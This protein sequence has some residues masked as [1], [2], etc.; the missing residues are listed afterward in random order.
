[1]REC[2]PLLFCA[3][4]REGK[5]KYTLLHNLDECLFVGIEVGQQLVIDDP[6]GELTVTAFDANH[7]SGAVMFL[8]EGNFGTIL[9][10]GDCRLTPECLQNLPEKY[11]GK[12]GKVPRCQ[13]DYLFLD[14]TFGKFSRKLPSKH[15]AIHQVIS[16]IWK[17]PDVPVVYLTC[18]LLGQEEILAVVSKTFGSKIF[19][20]K[21]S[22]PEC[23]Q[24]LT[25][26][27]PEVLSEDPS[28]RF[29]M[30]DGFPKLYERASAMLAEAQANFQPEP[31]IIRP[32][33]QWYACEEDD[34][35]TQ[36]QRKLRFNEAVRD[37]FGVWHV[38]YSMHSSREELEWALEL[39]APKRVVSTTPTC[40][41]MELDYVRKHCFSRITSDDPLWKLL[42]INLQTSEKLD[43]SDKD[44][45]CTPLLERPAQTSADSEPKPVK[46]S[47]ALKG[48]LNLSP[49]SKRPPVTLFGRARHS[50][51]DSSF[52][53][54]V[55]KSGKDYPPQI[56]VNRTERGFYSQEVDAAFNCKNSF[57]NE[58]EIAVTSE[59]VCK[60]SSHSQDGSCEEKTKESM[61]D[62]P[63][64]II[65][66]KTEQQFPSLETDAEVNHGHIIEK[67]LETDVA[68]QCGKFVEK[69]YRSSFHATID[70]SKNFNESLRNLY[71]SNNV[72]VPR[73]LP[74]LVEL[75]NANK[76][77]K[78]RFQCYS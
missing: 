71:R 3:G 41:A 15:S 25:L 16:C 28:S 39:L 8:F 66:K 31:L 45:V 23:F 46:R 73:P 53:C 69:D 52:S 7:C 30:L 75:I 58:E 61:K 55:K 20:D 33:A 70:R 14:C 22:N 49:P 12:R 2:H 18:D 5:E 29:R 21:T 56:V 37:Q 59:E 67:K 17:H 54:E 44:V 64:E 34:A 40:R 6:D 63:Q 62:D 50:L 47:A 48:I 11:V 35:E 51:E 32:S 74:S 68:I 78:R 72:P 19:V 9:H 10:T 26:M 27:V 13:L 76:R 1:M 65:A 24:S 57:E 36:S 77:A 4:E 60:S 38:C 43:V 42:D